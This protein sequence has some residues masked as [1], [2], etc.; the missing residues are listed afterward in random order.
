MFLKQLYHYNKTGFAVFIA[1]IIAFLYLNFKWGLV[2]TPVYQYGMYSGRYSTG[3]TQRVCHLYAG[4]HRLPVEE[5]H[6]SDRDLL[7]TMIEKYE[8][9]KGQNPLMYSTIN[10]I[11]SRFGL[12][13]LVKA[14]SYRNNVNDTIFMKW[15]QYFLYHKMNNSD[16][17]SVRY[18]QQL[19]QW[20]Q[21][22]MRPLAIKK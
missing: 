12:T 16:I 17:D 9:Q 22:K 6:F 13:N 15:L 2:A 11:Y 14:G 4:D 10:N 19:Y 20:Q 1:F 18:D 3:D 7:F 5:M 8:N 21:G